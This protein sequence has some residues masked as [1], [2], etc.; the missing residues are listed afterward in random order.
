MT[1]D[2][3]RPEIIIAPPHFLKFSGDSRG[4]PQNLFL[5]HFCATSKTTPN[6]TISV[7]QLKLHFPSLLRYGIV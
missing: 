4:F 5:H 7:C 6:P 3:N 2:G 1:Q